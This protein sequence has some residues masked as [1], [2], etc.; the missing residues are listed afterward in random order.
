MAFI[1]TI[2]TGNMGN[3]L[4]Q[5]QLQLHARPQGALS[6]GIHSLDF[7]EQPEPFH[8][9]KPLLA[10][11]S[12]DASQGSALA[13]ACRAG[14]ALLQLGSLQFTVWHHFYKLSPQDTQE[15]V[16]KVLTAHC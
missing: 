11:Q 3:V 1:G 10:A 5:F 14:A 9:T 6:A 13:G 7:S 2:A 15:S 12:N 8:P 16:R 4:F